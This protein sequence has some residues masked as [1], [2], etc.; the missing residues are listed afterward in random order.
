MMI[1]ALTDFPSTITAVEADGCTTF[2]VTTDTRDTGKLIGKQGRTAKSIRT[3][4]SA[5]GAAEGHRYALD[6]VQPKP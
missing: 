3:I 2:T 4:L 6:I 1:E 5:I